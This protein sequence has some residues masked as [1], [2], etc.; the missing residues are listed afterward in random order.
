MKVKI[1]PSILSADF[2]RLAEEIKKVESAG[3]DFV[4]IDIMDAH[5]VQNMTIGPPVVKCIRKET[6]LPLETH[7]MVDRPEWFVEEMAKVGVNIITIHVESTPCP[8]TLIRRIR[9]L[10]LKPGISLSPATK[11][12][13]VFDLLDEVDTVLIMAVNPGFPA[14]EFMSEVLPKIASLRRTLYL[15][16]LDGVEVAVDGGIN[17]KTAPLVVK[18]GAT[19]LVAGSAIY[20]SKDVTNAI[21]TLRKSFE[22]VCWE[23]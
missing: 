7:L 18:A 9:E 4:H 15:K 22:G 20:E 5:F 11:A 21:E 17:T 8:L 6:E 10:G 2:A 13:V 12:D 16:G 1:V 19:V 23:P 3:V 14:Q